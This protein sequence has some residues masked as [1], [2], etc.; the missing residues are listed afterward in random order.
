MKFYTRSCFHVL[1][2]FT[3]FV[4]LFG[5]SGA[6]NIAIHADSVQNQ[7]YE[8]YDAKD[9]RKFATLFDSY[10]DSKVRS[11]EYFTADFW[12]DF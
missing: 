6:D 2:V 10:Q 4:E 11:Q 7:V 3:A 8:T 12:N 9:I 5:N 1:S